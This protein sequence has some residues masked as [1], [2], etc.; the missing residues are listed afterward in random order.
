M[1]T[2]YIVDIADSACLVGFWCN[3][4]RKLITD[5]CYTVLLTSVVLLFLSAVGTADFVA[6]EFIPC[7]MF[8][9]PNP[10]SAV[11]TACPAI[12]GMI[13]T[14]FLIIVHVRLGGINSMAFIYLPG[15][16]FP[17]VKCRATIFF[18]PTA[19]NFYTKGLLI[20][21]RNISY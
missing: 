13:S 17:A 19:L 5:R 12:R 6:M 20:K 8:S 18:V 3:G 16:L 4:E 7:G 9:N 1:G 15:L 2:R 10:K 21:L 11:G 14:Y